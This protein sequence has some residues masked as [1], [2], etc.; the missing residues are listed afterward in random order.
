MDK[1]SIS[2]RDFAKKGLAVAATVPA[3]LLLASCSKKSTGRQPTEKEK[4]TAKQ[5]HDMGLTNGYQGKYL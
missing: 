1:N 5:L 3:L 4:R 2:R